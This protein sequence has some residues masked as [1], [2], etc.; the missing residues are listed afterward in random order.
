MKT[1]KEK[2]FFIDE[3]SYWYYPCKGEKGKTKDYE[4]VFKIKTPRQ[5]T[6]YL[7]EETN[8]VSN[9]NYWNMLEEKPPGGET[10]LKVQDLEGLAVAVDRYS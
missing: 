8:Q 2:E 1:D 5:E 4:L 7:L 10:T 3:Y 6:I 9:V